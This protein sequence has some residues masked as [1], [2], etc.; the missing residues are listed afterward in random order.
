MRDRA[1]ASSLV[2][3]LVVSASV[4][5][6]GEIIGDLPPV[7]GNG[8]LPGLDPSGMGGP[9]VEALPGPPTRTSG[10]RRLTRQEYARSVAR[11]LGADV[12][13]DTT[14]LPEDTLTP[15]DNDVL[16]Q[17]PSMLLVESTESLAT[18]IAKFVTGT[19]ARLQKLLPCT[20]AASSA[21]GA[22]PVCFDRF[23]QGFGRRVLRRPLAA[24]EIAAMNELASYG[25]APAGFADAANIALRVFLMHPEFLYRVELGMPAGKNRVRLSGYEMAS[26][27]SFLLHG[28]TP[29]DALLMAAQ[30][31]KLDNAEGRR[32]EALRLINAEEGKQQIRRFHA[33]W[34]GYSRLDSAPLQRK[35]RTET[36]ALVDRVT[37]PDV[38]W[39]QLLLS[40]DTDIDSELAS[41]YGMLGANG[42]G[43]SWVS[44]GTAPRRGILSHGMFA[45]AGAKFA[46]TSPTRRGKFIRER[47]L[48]QV[49]PLPAAEANVDVDLPPGGKAADGCKIDRYKQHREDAACAGCHAFMDPIGFGLENFDELGRYRTHDRDRPDCPIDGKG[50]LDDQN[51]FTGAKEL[52]SLVAASPRLGPC[53]SQHFIRFAAGRA[54]DQEDVQRAQWLGEE[55]EKAGNSFSAMLLSYVSHNDFGFRAE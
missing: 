24:D 20:P 19:P 23:V 5:C 29:D 12:P 35:L 28:A 30:T 4:A 33:F 55:M 52:A 49:I 34:L 39:R 11:L 45:A 13:V 1:T 51:T 38:D 48:C 46:D 17:S 42:S 27:L 50:A 47:F 2:T 16:E 18:D 37:E 22:D 54:L 14:L 31:G 21:N 53:V 25:K 36:D 8:M 41:H 44:Y 15:F 3:L 32:Q 26:R 43:F 7:G 9:P 10:A 6:S 40:D